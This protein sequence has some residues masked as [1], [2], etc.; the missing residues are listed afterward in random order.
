MAK[1]LTRK[2]SRKPSTPR[3]KSPI[4]RKATSATTSVKVPAGWKAYLPKSPEVKLQTL[5][6]EIREI[7]DEK[8]V[9]AWKNKDK[10][11]WVA[12]QMLRGGTAAVIIGGGGVECW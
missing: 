7:R 1:P 4:T 10:D 6:D 2:P 5:I 8:G 3:K 12:Y 11:H 9:D